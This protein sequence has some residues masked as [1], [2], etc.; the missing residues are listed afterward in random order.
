MLMKKLVLF[1]GVIVWAQGLLAQAP[2]ASAQQPISTVSNV[3]NSELF[4]DK[5]THFFYNEYYVIE[6]RQVY[7]SPFLFN[8]WENGIITTSDGRVF[9]GY[10]LKYNAFHQTVFFSNGKDSLEVNEEIREFVLA[11]KYPDSL[12]TSVFVN[13]NQYRKDK[14]PAYYEVLVDDDAGQ[15]L[16]HNKK[17][18][19][20]SMQG[21]PAYEGKKVFALETSYFYWDKKKKKLA[22]IKANGSN[23]G[24]ILGLDANAVELLKV[25][26][27]DFS[28]EENTVQFFRGY[29][30]HLRTK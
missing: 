8:D 24:D 18:V 21:I 19:A 14:K 7:G 30:Q 11:V 10:K 20:E 22:S 2:P 4:K 29:F 27:T 23:I 13:G 12:V 25:R 1:V 3:P 28:L 16:K 26:A 5:R 6:G 15:L 17:V 9:N